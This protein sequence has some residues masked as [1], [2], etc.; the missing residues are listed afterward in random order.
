[1][2][3]LGSFLCHLGHSWQNCL[4]TDAWNQQHKTAIFAEVISIVLITYSLSYTN[5]QEALPTS[6]T[7]C[8]M[9]SSIPNMNIEGHNLSFTVIDQTT[10]INEHERNQNCSI[11]QSWTGTGWQPISQATNH[12]NKQIGCSTW[13]GSHELQATLLQNAWYLN[14]FTWMVGKR[15]QCIVYLSHLPGQQINKAALMYSNICSRPNVTKCP[16]TWNVNMHTN[17]ECQLFSPMMWPFFTIS[18]SIKHTSN[19]QTHNIY[20]IPHNPM[21]TKSYIW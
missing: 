2:P 17:K 4:L 9:H 11:Q 13:T 5:V 6:D 3:S 12:I 20:N 10:I 21:W 8:T 16:S 7:T 1:M 19:K 14:Y 18:T 15:L